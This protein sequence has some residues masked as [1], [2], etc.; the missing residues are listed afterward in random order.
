MHQQGVCVCATCLEWG[1]KLQGRDHFLLSLCMCVCVCACEYIHVTLCIHACACWAQELVP[2][3]NLP[4]SIILRAS[5]EVCQDIPGLLLS[6]G[7]AVRNCHARVF[8]CGF[9]FCLCHCGR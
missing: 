8:V 1:G 3:Q 5:E 6:H 7:E 2:D 9:V 4:L